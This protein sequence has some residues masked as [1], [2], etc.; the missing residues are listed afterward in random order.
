MEVLYSLHIETVITRYVESKDLRR[1]V[2]VV[3]RNENVGSKGRIVV[4]KEGCKLRR[5]A[6]K[7]GSR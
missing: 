5:S 2:D 3:D 6:K 7:L 4:A 1:D